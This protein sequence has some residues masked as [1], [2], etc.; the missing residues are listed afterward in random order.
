[1]NKVSIV[2]LN[3]NRW[4]L[5][6][7]LLMDIY[8]K[9]SFQL[10]EEVLVVNNG[11]TQDESFTG[12]NWWIRNKILPIRELRLE[13][14]QG[15][16]GGFNAGLK[17]AKGDILIAL[18]NDVR[19]YGD[20]VNEVSKLASLSLVG[21]RLIDWDSGWNTFDDVTFP[22][23]EGWFLAAHREVWK[24]LDYFD[25]RYKPSDMEDVDLS[26]K[27][28]SCSLSLVTIPEGS[29]V[30][31]GAQT[32]GYSPERE[33]ITIRNKEKFKEKWIPKK[34]NL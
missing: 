5:V 34:D 17:A 12:L 1:M 31:M 30:H 23:L 11:C 9:C 22:Y 28:V 15:F 3:Y 21:A 2:I 32:I 26:S 18:S 24:D 20:V 16:I 33:A 19:I 27:A 13:E 6:H 29:V 7:Q 4:D 14:N 25:E 8:Q 10:I